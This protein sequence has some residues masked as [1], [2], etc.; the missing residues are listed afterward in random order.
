M[1]AALA[2]DAVSCARGG[3]MLFAD[4]SFALRAGAAAV[5]VGANGIGKSSLV[6]VAAG[7]LPP[8][9]GTVAIT[10]NRALL[11]EDNA[12]DP[13]L[14]LARALGFWAAIDGRPLPI[15]AALA[16]FD[17][18][19]LAPVPVRLLST[20][21]RKRAGL[22]RVAAS[23]APIWLL[24]EPANGLDQ[25]A[26]TLLEAAIAQHRAAGGIALVATHLPLALPGAHRIVLGAAA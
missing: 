19:A 9:A 14:P 5:V 18:T 8:A 16:A 12:L 25:R 2:F 11:T 10:G 13:E 7:L 24:D 26:T 6:R 4:L 1:S 21:Q 20:G 15:A 3:R 17:L 22:A 23:G